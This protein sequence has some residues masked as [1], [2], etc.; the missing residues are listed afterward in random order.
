MQLGSMPLLKRWRLEQEA[1]TFAVV[2][3]LVILLAWGSPAFLDSNNLDS[4]QTSMA[5]NMIIA[6]GMMV[7][8]IVGLFDLS[9]GA[10]MGLSGIITAL[11]LSAGYGMGAAI[12]CGLGVGIGIGLI[13]GLLVAVFGINHLIATLGVMYMTRG[14][15]EVLL[16]GAPLA[17]FT[18]FPL[19]FTMLGNGS[20]VGVYWMFLFA[21]ALVVV[22][23]FVLRRT[24]LGRRL[25][26]TGGNHDAA[27]LI[28]IDTKRMQ[29]GA[30]V[31]SGFMAALAGVLVT[32]RIGMANRYLGIGLEMNIIIACLVGGG[33]I[34]GGKGSAIGA[35]LGVA[36]ISL[37]TNA[38][39][40]FEVPS[41]WQS[42]V[43]GA[44]LVVV[45]AIDGI[46]LL[47]K[48]RVSWQ[49]IL[50]WRSPRRNSATLPAE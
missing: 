40:L 44:V 37:I 4:L 5:P 2:L 41:E 9:V 24:V 45:V 25:Y 43:I 17:G 3:L 7:L 11:V 19:A 31:F 46:L 22:G 30:L 38:F 36:F 14:V 39:N 10:V 12:A 28:G 16:L 42:S 34:A 26:F 1:I 23:E 29:I 48:Q 21:L 6:I 49:T 13:N 15:I 32:A 27:R 33:S 47:R 18:S 8:F 35:M 20:I 50:G